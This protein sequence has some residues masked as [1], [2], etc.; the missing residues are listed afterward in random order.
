MIDETKLYL[1]FDDVI[2]AN[3]NPFLISQRVTY[4]EDG[5]VKSKFINEEIQL[6]KADSITDPILNNQNVEEV[7]YYPKTFL[8]RLFKINSKKEL[9]FEGGSDHFVM[10]SKSTEKIYK[11]NCPVYHIEE[12][13]K[14]IIGKRSRII[15]QLLDGNLFLNV[16]KNNFKTILIR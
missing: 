14:V 1:Y 16:D 3:S 2:E 4:K 13:D 7:D 9:L 5:K 11:T 10:M 15:Y 12:D 8:K 6:E